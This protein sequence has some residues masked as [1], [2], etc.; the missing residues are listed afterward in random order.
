M[1]KENCTAQ[2]VLADIFGPTCTVDSPPK[3]TKRK[4][5]YYF[6]FFVNF[7]IANI[8]IKPFKKLKKGITHFKSFMY[9][10]TF[11]VKVGE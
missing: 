3:R 11:K 1:D 2:D 7:E 9:L 6:S 4:G 8:K 10:L 5:I